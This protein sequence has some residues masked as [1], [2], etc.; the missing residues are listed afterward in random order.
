MNVSTC[1]YSQ[2]EAR[3]CAPGDLLTQVFQ[4]VRCENVPGGGVGGHVDEIC[5][6][7]VLIC[8]AEAKAQAGPLRAKASLWQSLSRRQDIE[9]LTSHDE[10]TFDEICAL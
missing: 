4:C 10:F 5:G 2:D 7:A 8:R 3:V 9:T 6:R 1:V